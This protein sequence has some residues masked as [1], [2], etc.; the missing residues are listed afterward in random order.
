MEQLQKPEQIAQYRMFLKSVKERYPKYA[1]TSMIHELQDLEGELLD[2]HAQPG[3]KL[4][5]IPMFLTDD[6]ID[7]ELCRGGQDIS[8]KISNL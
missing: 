6:Y 5:D 7:K 8:G 4:P 2:Y 3:F 1:I